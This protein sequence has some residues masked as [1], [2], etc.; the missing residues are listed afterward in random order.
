M[1]R[2][3]DGELSRLEFVGK[4][5]RFQQLDAD[6]DGFISAKESRAKTAASHLGTNAK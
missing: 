5:D 3:N 1:D 4:L 2:N 6:H